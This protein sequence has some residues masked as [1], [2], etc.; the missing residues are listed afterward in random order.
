MR[1]AALLFVAL[2][3]VGAG[4]LLQRSYLRPE[5]EA[6]LLTGVSWRVPY[7]PVMLVP[8]VAVM[9]ADQHGVPRWWVLSA[10]DVRRY[11]AGVY[12]SPVLPSI[13]RV[14]VLAALQAVVV[15]LAVLA[16]ARSIA[17]RERASVTPPGTVP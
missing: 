2:W 17:R 8:R 16:L 11:L 15:Y 5:L 6:E 9:L 12:P 1:R 3:A 13:A 7:T 14:A 4:T 10:R